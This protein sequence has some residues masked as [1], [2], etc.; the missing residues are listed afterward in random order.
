LENDLSMLKLFVPVDRNVYS[1]LENISEQS[2]GVNYSAW[3]QLGVQW[4]IKGE[5]QKYSIRG[6]YEFRLLLYDVVNEQLLIGKRYMGKKSFMK[7]IMHKFAEEVRGQLTRKRGVA[8]T[9]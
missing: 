1:G 9:R 5:Y 6:K 3:S 8:E 2:D 7:I 4:L